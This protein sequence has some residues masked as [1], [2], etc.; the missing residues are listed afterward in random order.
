MLPQTSN[1]FGQVIHWPIAEV[2]TRIALAVAVGV[3]V[4]LEREH[5]QKTGVRTFALVSMLGCLGGFMGNIFPVVAMAFVGIVVVGMNY[6]EMVRHEKL[7][8]TTS[9]AIMI[10]GF[11]GILFG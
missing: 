1:F 4:G 9:V 6:R 5:S 2:L 8:L 10:V 3:F 7:V 11:A